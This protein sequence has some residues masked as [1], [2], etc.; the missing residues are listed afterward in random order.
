MMKVLYL[1]DN[2]WDRELVEEVLA[3]EG[4]EVKLV[5][6]REELEEVLE[7]MDFSVVLTDLNVLG[8][9]GLKVLE[10]VREKDPFMPVVLLTGTGSEELAVEALKR[11]A[12]DYVVKTPKHIKRLPETIRRAVEN[13][14]LIK[15]NEEAQRALRESER[16]LHDI[17]EGIS[18][19]IAVYRGER[20]LYVNRAMEKITGYSKQELLSNPIWTVIA[21]EDRDRVKERALKRQMGEGVP[22]RYDF[23][24]LQKGGGRRWVELR[25]SRIRWGDKLVWLGTFFD[26]TERKEAEEEREELLSKYKKLLYQ[27]VKAFSSAV[28]IKEPYTAGH[29]KRVAE[30]SEAIAKEMGIDKERLE[31]IKVAALLHDIGKG[32]GVPLEVLNK[33]GKLNPIEFAF[34][35]AHPELGYRILKEV[36]FPWPV[37]EAI[38]QHHERLDGS[39]YPRGLKGEQI[40]LEARIIAVADVVEA[41][42]SHRPYR[43]SLG[44]E[45]ALE[46]IDKNKGVLY[47]PTV[48]AA[49]LKAFQ[50]GFKFE[51]GYPSF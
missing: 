39:G 29:Q 2:L 11:G 21:P 20:H 34:V 46:E 5:S 42:T 45:S 33:P 7:K 38:L 15:E 19:G 43:A 40:I 24:I 6:C 9:E 32:L 35:K 1:E 31:G 17:L 28:E 23:R 25:S 16:L 49:C 4:F 26:I 27:I 18:A 51:Q 13:A 37:A 41:I 47:D 36:E 10:I 14:R 44:L 8:F 30:L 50:K 3:K 12:M 48:V 22:D